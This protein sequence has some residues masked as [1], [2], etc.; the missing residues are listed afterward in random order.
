MRRREIF[1]L[2]LICWMAASAAACSDNWESGDEGGLPEAGVPV[3]LKIG[4]RATPEGLQ[5]SLYVFRKGE[6]DTDY[7]LDQTLSLQAEG[8]D[9]IRLMNDDLRKYTYR[10]LFVATPQAKP[11]IAVKGKD[12][13]E[14]VAGS[15]TWTD[16][17]I[18]A[19]T[20]SLTAENY[21]G[22]LD[23]EGTALL[24]SGSIDGELTRLVGQLVFEFYR[25]GPD[26]T[27]TPVEIVS[28]D[29]LSVLD[30]VYRID[31]SYTGLTQAVRFGTGNMPEAVSPAE[32]TAARHISLQTDGDL[33]VSVPQGVTEALPVRGGVRFKGEYALPANGNV[34]AELVFHYY[35][36]TPICENNHGTTPHTDACYTLKEL[37]LNIA[38]WNNGIGLTVL[39]DYYTL[40]RAGIHCNRIID[41]ATTTGVTLDTKWKNA[42]K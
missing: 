19:V 4:G 15:T 36:T 7:L 22:I 24:K 30:R 29:V 12:G 28:P 23:R 9:R 25:V 32:G 5:Y 1:R 13:N 2:L 35:D 33:R 31:L 21:S 27:G 14:A 42:F 38:D 20:D 8:Q 18:I 26:G 11:E 3:A 34:R 41:I 16:L 17:R 37:R 39:P 10:F 6:T 40:N